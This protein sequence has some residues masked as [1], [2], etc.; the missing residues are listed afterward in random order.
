MFA[1]INNLAGQ[2]YLLDA[3]G[4]FSAV[5]LIWILAIYYI[6]CVHQ[7]NIFSHYWHISVSVLIIGLIYAVSFITGYLWFEARPFVREGANL[8]ISVPY[9]VKS[10]P[11]DH[12]SIAFAIA[13]AC[14]HLKTRWWRWSFVAA[15]LV[16][17]GRVFVGVHYFQDVIVGAILGG[18]LAWLVY[19]LFDRYFGK[20]R[21][22]II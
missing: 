16:A 6:W 4:I 19:K 12:A 18:G 5:W 1:F 7:Q 21:R 22:A 17:L 3:L 9:T 14:W 10:F 2:N 20:L 13:A 11:S 15:A 8:L